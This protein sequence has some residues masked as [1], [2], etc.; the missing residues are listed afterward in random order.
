[1]GKFKRQCPSIRTHEKRGEMG[2]ACV[3]AKE[4]LALLHG[5]RRREVLDAPHLHFPGGDVRLGVLYRPPSPS[6]S[7][8]SLLSGGGGVREEERRPR[9]VVVR[10]GEGPDAVLMDS[11]I[12]VE[13]EKG[14]SGEFDL[15]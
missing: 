9:V 11:L 8:S 13:G 2:N 10:D 5:R 4:G 3:P 1:M 14:W 12:W 15:G 6:L 7:S